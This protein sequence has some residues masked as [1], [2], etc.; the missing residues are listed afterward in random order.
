MMNN[1]YVATPDGKETMLAEDELLAGVSTG[2]YAAGTLIWREGL[3][4]WEPIEKHF[5]EAF[6]KQVFTARRKSLFTRKGCL[7]GAV[8]LLCMCFLPTLCG[9][10]QGDSVQQ[11]VAAAVKEI[12]WYVGKGDW[13]QL[14]DT[15]ES[16]KNNE[17]YYSLHYSDGERK[18]KP[19]EL[20]EE[21]L[22]YR[23]W[24][25]LWSRSHPSEHFTEQ[26]S[27]GRIM[28]EIRDINRKLEYAHPSEADQLKAALAQLKDM[29]LANFIQLEASETMH[30]ATFLA[31]GDA[32]ESLTAVTAMVC[33]L[34]N[35]APDNAEL[36]FYARCLNNL[37]KS[38][39]MVSKSIPWESQLY[40]VDE[41][42]RQLKKSCQRLE[43]YQ[44]ESP[45][46]L[47][48]LRSQLRKNIKRQIS[49]GKK[50]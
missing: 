40:I 3:E 37:R 43:L 21:Q 11:E 5:P 42:E 12:Q 28:S 2:K 17:V 24:H 31:N 9:E 27:L 30:M 23:A 14:H 6:K 8:A 18:E 19:D 25:S 47:A 26:S 34:S 45:Q 36:S 13:S 49:K 46:E 20:T 50:Q 29:R 16:M 35:A 22:N 15:F 32:N 48:A 39:C 33:Q 1:W 38:A 4:A 10:K 44:Y 41:Y 7:I